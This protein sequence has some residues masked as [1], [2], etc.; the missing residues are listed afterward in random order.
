MLHLQRLLTHQKFTFVLSHG[1][2]YVRRS[3][4]PFAVNSEGE[5]RELT[6]TGVLLARMNQ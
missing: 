3:I 2:R 6:R 1:Q 4:F 5:K